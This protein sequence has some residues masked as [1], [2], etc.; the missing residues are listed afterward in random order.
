MISFVISANEVTQTAT[1][2]KARK[3]F[4]C[5]EENLIPQDG[6]CFKIKDLPVPASDADLAITKDTRRCLIYDED[7]DVFWTM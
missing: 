2:R 5:K 3:K 6:G 4:Y 7:I 1:S